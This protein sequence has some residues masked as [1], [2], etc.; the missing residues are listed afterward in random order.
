MTL[1]QGAYV[2][3]AKGNQ[4]TLYD[5]LRLFF[6]DP[7]VDCRDW[8]SA[9]TCDKGHGRLEMRHLIASTELNDFLATPWSG[10]AQV[11]R[12]RRRVCKP[13]LCTQQLVYGITSLTPAQA[14]PERLLELIR[15]HWAIEN[16]LHRRR[17]VTFQEDAC[18]VRKGIAP[19]IL[20]I[21]NSFLLAVFDW[22]GVRNVASQ[23]R[24]CSAR[25]ILALRLLLLSLE[26]I[27]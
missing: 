8:R 23:M 6:T 24:L 17:D 14:S 1:A 27:K 25:P 26:K 20:T 18:Q 16:R 19:R 13:L 15:D 9:E 4:A 3:F 7:P 21:L 12:L 5:D 22:L 2:L 11:F 10:I